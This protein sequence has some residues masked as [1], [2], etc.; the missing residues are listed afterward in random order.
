MRPHTWSRAKPL[1]NVAGNT[2]IGH[3]LNLMSAITDDEVVFVIGYKGDEIKAWI[4]SYYPH[5]NS[6][7]VLQEQ[8]LGQAHAMWLCR[9]YMDEDEILVA[10]GDGIVEADYAGI[11]ETDADAVC[12]IQ[13]VD[14]PRTF[15]V[16]VVNEEGYITD[17]IEKPATMDHKLALAGIYWFRQGKLLRRALDAVISEDRK[18][19]GEYYLADAYHVLLESGVTIAAKPT[20]LWLDAGKPDYMLT[21][22][23]RL[24]AL[25]HGSADAIERSYGEDFTVLPPVFVHES[26]NVVASVIGPYVNIEAGATIRNCVISNSIIDAGTLVENCVLD[27]ALIGEKCRVV[28]QREA[29]FVGDNSEVDMG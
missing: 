9:D 21:A 5:L 23:A 12:L 13:E 8:A 1:L 2:V 17:F 10:F 19:K 25:G 3:L 28:G 24:L 11:S 20:V 16:A 22:N 27:G 4:R 7:F 29:L 26:A 14:D 6:R 15:G 18:T